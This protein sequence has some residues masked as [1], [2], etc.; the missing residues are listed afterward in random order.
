M[1][2][3]QTISNNCM[4]L[5]DESYEQEDDEDLEQYTKQ[6]NLK[7]LLKNQD[8]LMQQINL[9]N[10]Q[11]TL[12]IKQQKYKEALKLLQQSEQMLEFAAS[13]GRVIDR[14]LIII[15]LYNQACAYQC[16][17]V[18]DKCSK[19]LDGVIYNMELA[20]KEDELD[21]ENFATAQEKQAQLVKRYTFLAKA[22]LQYTAILSQ[23]GKHN[24]ALVNS[25]KAASTMRE[26][27]KIANHFCQQWLQ[28]NGLSGT[29]TTSQSNISIRSNQQEQQDQDKQKKIQKYHMKDEIEFG[30]L[31]IDG[32]KDILKDMIKQVDLEKIPVNEK[33]LLKE[34]KKQLYFWKNNPENNEKH[35]RKELKLVSQNEEYRSLLGI[36]NLAE[37][38]K[39]F[40]I[41]SI[42][43]MIPQVYDDFTQFG[44]MIYELAKRQILEKVIYFSISYF[45]IATEL[46]FIELEKAKQ[47]GLKEDKIDTEE[48][49]LSDM[50]HLK[51]I[52]IACRHITTQS[53]Y[54]SHLIT[55][56]HKHYNI[57]LDVI[58][59]ES[60]LSSTSEKQI[61]FLSNPESTQQLK[62][63][64]K[65]QIPINNHN[66]NNIK[67]DQSPK[68]TNNFITT[69]LNSRSPPKTQQQSQIK[70]IIKNQTNLIEQMINQKR[71]S[72]YSPSNQ[73]NN[74]KQQNQGQFDFM[75]YLKKQS[76]PCNTSNSNINSTQ[77][78]INNTM[79]I[80]LQPHKNNP[81]LKSN[82]IQQQS[83]TNNNNQLKSL[84]SDVCR[85]ERQTAIDKQ[86]SHTPIS[87]RVNNRSPDS[88]YIN[89]QKIKQQQQGHLNKTPQN[90]PRTNTEQQQPCFPF[91]F[92][93]IQSLLRNQGNIYKQ[94]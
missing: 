93:T 53:P 9:L 15:I 41:G 31:V 7:Q 74:S 11:A 52:E 12:K 69:F 29:A 18:L 19:Y 73:K 3:Q 77:D 51:A 23:M 2:N 88:S 10:E 54:I 67:Q 47:M 30:K 5:D 27:F 38:I 48:F 21:L 25:Q 33:Q 13:C 8:S 56:Y 35:L 24:M 1:N 6:L 76:N 68:L 58:K 28:N 34:A 83:P 49:K 17:W 72:D 44:E 4:V 26:L 75:V 61:T 37:W 45:T 40:N 64:Q 63:N 39:N 43:H 20:I 89:S 42:M 84:L 87:Y 60:I 59:E 90:R 66:K 46:R 32:A 80:Q 62:H 14:N 78:F 81:N 57:N 85:T 86:N 92:E 91:K 55:S 94:K 79:T 50:Y 70:N 22:Y 65:I 36:Q 71:G 82:H 16:Q